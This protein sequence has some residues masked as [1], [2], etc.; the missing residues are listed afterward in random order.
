[1]ISHDAKKRSMPTAFTFTSTKPSTVITST[2][3]PSSTCAIVTGTSTWM[4]T[5]LRLKYGSGSTSIST[6]RSPGGAPFGPS[7]PWPDSRTVVLVSTPGGIST[8]TALVLRSRLSSQQKFP[9]TT[10]SGGTHVCVLVKRH[11]INPSREV[12]AAHTV[13][14]W[15]LW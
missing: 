2:L 9:N 14:S 3:E 1:M 7:A 5:P 10:Q 6:N 15:G 12:V 13:L 8:V 4:S 11:L